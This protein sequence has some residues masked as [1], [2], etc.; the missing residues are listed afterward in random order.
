[1][2]L[3]LSSQIFFFN[4]L[5]DAVGFVCSRWRSTAADGSVDKYTSHV[6]FLM[7]LAQFISCIQLCMVQN[8]PPNVFTCVFDSIFML[9]MMCVWLSVLL[10]LS[11]VNLFYSLFFLHSDQHYVEGIN[12]CAFAQ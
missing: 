1:M 12:H 7:Q 10:F 3:E 4:N 9:C 5:H 11:V 2:E 6:I 8:E